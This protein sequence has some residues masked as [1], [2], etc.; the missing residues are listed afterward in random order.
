MG[1]GR[2]LVGSDGSESSMRAVER[3][4][5]VAS[6]A[7]A[8]LIVACAYNPVPGRE[9]AR[10]TVALEA[11]TREV[12][13]EQDARIALARS[14]ERINTDRTRVIDQVLVAGEPAAALLEA[15]RDHHVDLIVVGNRG[16]DAVAGEL[17]GS[18]PGDVARGAPCDVLIVQT[19]PDAARPR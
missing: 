2:V 15:A 6:A 4:A 17:L 19:D 14:M 8:G 11:T 1:Y 12:R 9:Q 16:L 18:V 10:L 13:G 3:A 7:E 5:E